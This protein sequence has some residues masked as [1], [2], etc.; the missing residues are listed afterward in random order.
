MAKS[1]NTRQKEI[2]NEEIQ[3]EKSFFTADEIHK[4]I[5]K[6]DNK[7]GI[8][9]VYRFLK[10]LSKKE[11]IHSYLCNKKTIYSIDNKSHCHFVCEKCGEITHFNVKK[12]D[13]I[14]KSLSEEICHFQID[15]KGICKKCKKK[16]ND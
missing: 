3:K 6:K 10:D 11:N 16:D 8:A 7:I 14:E 2:L 9:T 5:K 1:R 4:K 15:V 12:I 13:F